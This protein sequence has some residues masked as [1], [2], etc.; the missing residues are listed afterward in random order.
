[1]YEDFGASQEKA[2]Y[3]WRRG[4]G[5]GLFVR[6]IAVGLMCEDFGACLEKMD[7]F[8]PRESLFEFG[9]QNGA[10]APDSASYTGR[11]KWTC[12]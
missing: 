6:S 7:Y 12:L 4:S 8:W 1:M 3:F 11:V 5:R 10:S 9:A 2:G